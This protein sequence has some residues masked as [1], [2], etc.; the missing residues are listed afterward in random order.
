MKILLWYLILYMRISVYTPTD[1]YSTGQRHI[2][3]DQQINQDRMI[4]AD[5]SVN[6]EPI[7]MFFS[8]GKFREII[9]LISKVRPFDM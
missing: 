3:I 2:E 1:Y 7:F 8:K 5:F 6:T 4:F 9:W